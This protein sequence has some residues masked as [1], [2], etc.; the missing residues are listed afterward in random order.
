MP[1]T[2]DIRKMCDAELY[3]VECDTAITA[4][5]RARKQHDSPAVAAE[6]IEQDDDGYVVMVCDATQIS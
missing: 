3:K 6:I 1:R 2:T 5:D 4:R